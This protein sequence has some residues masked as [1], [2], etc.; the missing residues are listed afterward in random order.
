MRRLTAAQTLLSMGI[1]D[2]NPDGSGHGA[3]KIARDGWLFFAISIPLT[4]LTLSL[5]YAWQRFTVPRESLPRSPPQTPIH[6]DD[7]KPPYLKT[8]TSTTLL[9]KLHLKR[10]RTTWH[11]DVTLPS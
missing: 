8:S 11:T 7:T 9:E 6:D 10:P 4:F 1:F 3:V 5:A 2:F